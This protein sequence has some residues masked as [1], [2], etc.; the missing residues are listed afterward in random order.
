MMEIRRV[1]V[2]CVFEYSAEI[3]TPTV[4]QVQPL[5]SA[6]VAVVREQFDI[7]P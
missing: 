3:P 4:F 5:D 6:P 7:E 1:L 2:G